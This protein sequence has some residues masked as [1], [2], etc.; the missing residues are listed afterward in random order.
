[1]SFSTAWRVCGEFILIRGN[2][3]MLLYS[4][5]EWKKLWE[6][7][8]ENLMMQPWQKACNMSK[9]W[10]AARNFRQYKSPSWNWTKL[11]SPQAKVFP[12]KTHTEF[13]AFEMHNE[14]ILRVSLM[15]LLRLMSYHVHRRQHFWTCQNKTK[16]F[17]LFPN[18]KRFLW[19]AP[20][21]EAL[22]L[23]LSCFAVGWDY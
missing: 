17:S 22:N 14:K 6:I 10:N 2:T 16:F 11:W 7:T 15:K 9:Y 19:T 8:N 13:V 12:Q 4:E 21:V 23:K 3:I 20:T 5:L 18:L 1:M